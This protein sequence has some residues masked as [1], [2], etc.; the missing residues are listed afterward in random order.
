MV[1]PIQ[2]PPAGRGA[3]AAGGPDK[4]KVRRS[5]HDFAGYSA[6]MSADEAFSVSDL[7]DLLVGGGPVDNGSAKCGRRS[8]E[9]KRLLVRLVEIDPALRVSSRQNI[10][11]THQQSE[12]PAKYADAQR[13]ARLPELWAAQAGLTH[14]PTGRLSIRSLAHGVR[15]LRS[16][17]W[18][19]SACS[20]GRSLRNHL[21]PPGA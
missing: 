10:L 5:W 3:E 11:G 12:H 19:R 20:A 16:I 17:E 1:R 9:A 18:F 21:G 7:R 6:L 8:N 15:D 2:R 4:T 14:A 13:K